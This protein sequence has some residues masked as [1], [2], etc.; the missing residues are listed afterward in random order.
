MTEPSRKSFRDSPWRYSQFVVLGLVV[1]ALVTWL[2]PL[3][4]LPSLVIG[5]VVAVVYLLFEKRRGVI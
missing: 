2:S 1:A 3:G 4:W 5:A